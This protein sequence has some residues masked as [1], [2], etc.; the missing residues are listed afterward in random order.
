MRY[1]WHVH[2]AWMLAYE[3]YTHLHFQGAKPYGEEA[4]TLVLNAL[5]SRDRTILAKALFLVSLEVR[6]LSDVWERRPRWS[7]RAL[8]FS[9]FI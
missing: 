8:I 2:G 7:P 4:E 3:I 6:G 1:A 9:P 5:R